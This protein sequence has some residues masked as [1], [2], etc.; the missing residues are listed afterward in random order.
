MK[1]NLVI[2]LNSGTSFDGID[3]ALV[4]FKEKNLKPNFID[5]F[6]YEYPR[7]VKEELRQLIEYTEALHKTPLLAISQLNFL[8]GE[9]FADAAL[10]II[11]KNKLTTKDIF[12]I[13]SHGQTIF[14]KGDFENILGKKI[15]S[16]FQIGESSVIAQRTRI[17]TVS[18]FRE[19]DIACG[20]QGAPLMPFLDFLFFG[21]DKGLKAT[22]NIGGIANISIVGKNI[23]PIGFDTGPG[24][25]LID[26]ACKKY[27]NKDYDNSGELAKKGKII[28]KKV[29]NA[30]KN[31]YFRKKP[32]KTTGKEY[33]NCLFIE[34]YFLD[35]RNKKDM[36]ATLTYFT[37]RSIHQ[38]FIDYIYPKYDIKEIIISGGG[39]KNKILTKNLMVLLPDIRFTISDKYGLPSKFKEAILFATLAYTCYKGIPN[40]IPSCTGAK[41]KVVLGKM[42][43]V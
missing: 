34:K 36:I 37:A 32:P 42:T 16:S 18:N 26:L 25:S 27:F 17:K 24:N 40:N 6:V 15:R 7:S 14:H 21:K 19:S 1:N 39:T 33:F 35:I 3:V 13:G 29:K 43:F 12:L 30:L 38:A 23:T 28:Y 5:G 9:I 4:N 22:L 11:K 2:G 10:K 31:E 20:G 41:N 8:L